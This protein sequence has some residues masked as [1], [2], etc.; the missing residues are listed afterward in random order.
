MKLITI[1]RE[2]ILTAAIF[3]IMAALAL[4]YIREG[5]SLNTSTSNPSEGEIII[6]LVTGEFKSELDGN[7]IEAYRWDPGTIVIPS[8][9]NVTLKILGVNG[10]KHPF[11]IEGT[12]IKGTVQKGQETVLPLNL[13]KPGTYR[14]ICTAHHD[15]KSNGPMI[16]YIIA[17]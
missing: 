1:K 17:K 15:L 8:N 6:N 4:F 14:L 2:W 13:K 3:A 16:A 10:M 7:I 9:K 11:Y 5:E 12:N